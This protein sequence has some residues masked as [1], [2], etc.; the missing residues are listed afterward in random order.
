MGTRS[1]TIAIRFS[2][3]FYFRVSIFAAAWFCTKG[4]MIGWINFLR[5]SHLCP[6]VHGAKTT[7]ALQNSRR[8]LCLIGE[9]PTPFINFPCIAFVNA[10]GPWKCAF[11]LNSVCGEPIRGCICRRRADIKANEISICNC[12]TNLDVRHDRDNR[13]TTQ[14]SNGGG[15]LIGCYMCSSKRRIVVRDLIAL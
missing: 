3:R 11:D 13:A 7:S 9:Y 14:Y 12:T 15:T 1:P 5:C 2:H 4:E 6:S 10:L 8:I